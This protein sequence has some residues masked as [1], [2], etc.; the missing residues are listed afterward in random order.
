[1]AYK[2]KGVPDEL[3]GNLPRQNIMDIPGFLSGTVNTGPPVAP[4]EARGDILARIANALGVTPEATPSP[5]AAEGMTPAMAA[6]IERRRQASGK[7]GTLAILT[8]LAGL[9]NP[10][11]L[12]PATIMSGEAYRSAGAVR[13]G[14]ARAEERT[15]IRKK[16]ALSE[17]GMQVQEE[18]ARSLAESR[19]A[20][21]QVRQARDRAQQNAK[22]Y[23][24]E[25]IALSKKQANLNAVGKDLK[26]YELNHMKR[27]YLLY[28][29]S[30]QQAFNFGN[31]MMSSMAAQGLVP[32]V[33]AVPSPTLPPF[34]EFI[35]GGI[36]PAPV[37]TPQGVPQ[38]I[39]AAA[40]APAGIS[41]KTQQRLAEFKRVNSGVSDAEL[42]SY[43]RSVYGDN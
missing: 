5:E 18:N 22:K 9:V 36:T 35:G 42:L 21:A 4:A 10:A 20:M 31:M 27:V 7:Q 17:R 33:G 15:A 26:P 3:F 11:L 43:I 14:I 28:G 8:A 29:Q 24:Q 30:V 40:G 25:L 37:P 2:I 38:G 41:A 12:I 32:G 19:K 6:E 16:E 1:M 23:E 34:E 39:P 13:G